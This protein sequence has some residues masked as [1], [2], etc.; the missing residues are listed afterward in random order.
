[1]AE[2]VDNLA[3][4]VN[5]VLPLVER[6]RN[7]FDIRYVIADKA[8]LSEKVVGRL[9]EMGMRAVI[10]V[11]KRW[12]GKTMRQYYEAFQDLI[13]WYDDRQQ[14]FHEVYRLR[15]KVEAFFSMVKTL[16]SGFCWSRGRRRKDADGNP[17]GNSLQ[18]C[19]AWKN[20]TLCK[21][22][23]VNLRTTVHHEVSTGYR[24]RYL[25]DT[26]FPEIP[27]NDRLVA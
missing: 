20:E 6:S 8:Y 12:D 22:I 17:I 27:K 21:L 14:S 18:P 1:V 4:D 24:M 23:Y 13:A 2:D 10:P 5:F 19:T 26:F 16:S 15:P 11:K 3:H 25:L 9:K 7:I